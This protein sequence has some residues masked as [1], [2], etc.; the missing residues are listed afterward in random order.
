MTT[1]NPLIR[2][3]ELGQ[4]PWLD[5]ITRD[6]ITSGALARLIADDG[7]QGMTSNPTIFEKAV[8]GSADY[9]DDVRRLTAEGKSP[10]AVFEALAVQD[11]RAA[12]DA[13]LP[14][15]DGTG[16]R[17]GFVSIEVSPTLARDTDGTIAEA[18]RLWRAVE[19]P[20]AMIKIPGTKAGLPA[21]SA[22]LAEGINVNVTLLF[23]VARYREVIEAFLAGVEARAAAGQP[24]AQLASVASFFVSRVDTRV[25]ALLA[26]R[27]DPERLRGTIGIANAAMAYATFEQLLRTD[28]WA[29]LSDSG[30]R[31]QRP[32]WA[33]TSTKDPAYP[34][35]Y[36]VEALV[37]ADTVDTIPPETLD[38][39]RDHGH[40]EHRIQLAIDAAPARL[41]ALARQ[42]IDLDEVTAFL[43]DEGVTKFAKSYHSLLAA[44]EAKIGAVAGRR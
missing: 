37:A 20:N 5:Y 40:P 27:G 6:L 13:F 18:R 39:Y 10:A 28:R 17:H 22:C 26:E 33:S 15:Y 21:I 7:L 11:V 36:Y 30:V 44:I 43:E 4:S 41:A 34:D 24:V 25:D 12:C 16:G 9:D 14:T 38:A 8:T 35:V 2:L 32:L 42:G 29:R 3:G 1:T 23:S 31:P 19:R